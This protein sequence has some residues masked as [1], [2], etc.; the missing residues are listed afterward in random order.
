MVDEDTV[1]PGPMWTKLK[2]NVVCSWLM[3][4]NSQGES[5][6]KLITTALG[7]FRLARVVQPTLVITRPQ[8]GDPN[9]DAQIQM[10]SV[11]GGRVLNGG[12]VRQ[13]M[14][15][16]TYP[17][18]VC[19][20]DGLSVSTDGGTDTTVVAAGH[21]VRVFGL[22]IAWDTDGSFNFTSG[23]MNVTVGTQIIAKLDLTKVSLQGSTWISCPI[24]VTGQPGDDI[25]LTGPGFDAGA[26][27]TRATVWYSTNIG[28][29]L[30]V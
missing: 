28:N 30:T 27:K 3:T 6:W 8:P 10:T 23:S 17:S 9:A 29:P 26:C 1:P 21:F 19:I 4:Y 12:E 16:K 2:D 13:G 14:M 7:K 22:Q 15:V 18:E 24:P 25:V 11:D 20:T 5:L